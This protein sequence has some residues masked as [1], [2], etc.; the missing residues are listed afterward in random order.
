MDIAG[1]P[2][3]VEQ[4]GEQAV[5]LLGEVVGTTREQEAMLG[6]SVGELPDLLPTL[7]RWGLTFTHKSCEDVIV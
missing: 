1:L 2:I 7:P 4:P 5:I 6:Q 3:K